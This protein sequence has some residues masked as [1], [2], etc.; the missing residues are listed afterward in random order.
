MASTEA[1]ESRAQIPTFPRGDSTEEMAKSLDDSGCLIITDIL[2]EDSLIQLKSELA[3]FMEKAAVAGDNP[4]DFYPGLTRRVTALAARSSEVRSL[5]MHPTSLSLCDHHLS[6]N[7]EQIQLHA[8]AALEIGP[9]ARDQILHRE[10][11][12]FAFFPLPRPNLVLA[13]MWSVSEFVESNGATHVVPGSHRWPADREPAD[14]EIAIAE[15]PAGS[16][17]F[18]TG[19][20]LHG[21]GANTTDGWRYGVILTYSCGWLRQEE[22]QYLDVRRED[23]AKLDPELRKM[24]G[25][26]MHGALGFHDPSLWAPARA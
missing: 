3:P 6:A 9:G 12:P 11:D 7:C 17:L 14:D 5:I 22:N 1:P 10:E 8:T 21:A 16:V 19:G 15:M 26:T 18:W 24:L 23:V 4:D 20:L 13:T 2:S 25:F